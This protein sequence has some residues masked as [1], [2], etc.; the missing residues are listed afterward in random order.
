MYWVWLGGLVVV[1]GGVIVGWPQR[2]RRQEPREVGDATDE[3]VAVG[4]DA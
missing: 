3:L 4:A 2:R 1:V